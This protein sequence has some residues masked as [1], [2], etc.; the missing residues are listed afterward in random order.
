M[1]AQTHGEGFWQRMWRAA[2]HLGSRVRAWAMQSGVRA[3]S[4]SPAP[5]TSSGAI[6]AAGSPRFLI[7]LN[8]AAAVAQILT[9][10]S[11]AVLGGRSIPEVSAQ[12]PTLVT[13]ADGAFTVWALIY[14]AC[15]VYALYQ[16]R[17]PLR[18]EALLVRLRPYTA[19]AFVANAVWPFFFQR[20]WLGASAL[21][22]LVTL[23]GLLGVL[24]AARRARLDTRA[25]RLTVYTLSIFAGWIT[26]ATVVNVSIVLSALGVSGGAW[27]VP[28]LL[29]T[30][31]IGAGVTVWARGNLGYALTL[32]WA[33]G[34]I[35][36][37]RGAAEGA[38]SLAAAVSL[39]LVGLGLWWARRT[40]GPLPADAV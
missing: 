27:A 32:I 8:V 24:A 35:T 20:E 11:S 21:N 15:L 28:V 26:V 23:A 25:R 33:L 36:A 17:A 18:A 4:A 7:A 29:V 14:P 19:L 13:P 6:P 37:A 40:R 5:Q 38:A 9:A 34:W 30:G 3:G 31:L 22:I 10:Q 16:A 1:T 2:A 12:Y 39:A